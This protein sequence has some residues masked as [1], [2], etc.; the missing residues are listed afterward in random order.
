MSETTPD[1]QTEIQR[2][3]TAQK[4]A[5]T[6]AHRRTLAGVALLTVVLGTTPFVGW[7]FE[8]FDEVGRKTPIYSSDYND[9]WSR[10]ADA[11]DELES[12]RV[13]RYC[14]A[15]AN[16]AGAATAPGSVVSYRAVDVQCQT[17]CASPT[18][19]SCTSTEMVRSASDG[20][21]IPRGRYSTGSATNIAQ[22]GI[23]ADCD[24]WTN[25][26]AGAWAAVWE[27]PRPIR[28]TCAQSIPF[29]CCD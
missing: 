26:D 2:L 19:H 1:L 25:A 5:Q 27:S 7:S 21:T 16:S 20:M 22:G 14:A 11:I 29:L 10:V 12:H 18:A 28:D 9:R 3:R 15:T 6:A 17:A 24:G 4:N 8:A 23:A 13:G